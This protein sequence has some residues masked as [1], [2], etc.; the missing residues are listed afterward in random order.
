MKQSVRHFETNGLKILAPPRSDKL[1]SKALN[2]LQLKGLKPNPLA[3]NILERHCT[4]A[5]GSSISKAKKLE[6][7]QQVI[8]QPNFSFHYWRGARSWHDKLMKHLWRSFVSALSSQKAV[9]T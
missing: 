2:H 5:Y 3:Y 6:E 8:P 4:K 7:I 9:S 1:T